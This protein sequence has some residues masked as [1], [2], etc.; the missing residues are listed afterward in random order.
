MKT[1]DIIQ[2]TSGAVDVTSTPFDLGDLTSY[3]ASVDFTGSDLAGTLTLEASNDNSDY[4]TVASSSQSVTSAAS[5]MWNI[6]GAS[7]RY[8]RVKWV[9]SSGTGN[10]SAKL[11][12]KEMTVKGF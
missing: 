11:I 4:I 3:S 8:V 12:A 10:I 9:A 5:H 7:Y 1:V 2:A 6:S